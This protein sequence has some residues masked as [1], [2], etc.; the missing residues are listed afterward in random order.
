MCN[1]CGNGILEVE[2][3]KTTPRKQLKFKAINWGREI[4]INSCLMFIYHPD[5]DIFV[6]TGKKWKL[7]V[8]LLSKLF[9]IQELDANYWKTIYVTLRVQSSVL[10]SFSR[11]VAQQKLNIWRCTMS[12]CLY[13]DVP[14]LDPVWLPLLSEWP[15][16]IRLEEVQLA[17]QSPIVFSFTNSAAPRQWNCFLLHRVGWDHILPRHHTVQVSLEQN[18]NI[19][20]LRSDENCSIGAIMFCSWC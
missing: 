16:I 14:D 17:C 4:I 5:V 8:H 9:V 6:W 15:V 2:Q 11:L 12:I 18:Q 10:R 19:N 20:T 13:W 1:I 7:K 3:A